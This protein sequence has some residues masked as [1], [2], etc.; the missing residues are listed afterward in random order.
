MVSMAAAAS[1]RSGSIRRSRSE[2]RLRSAVRRTGVYCP[3]LSAM[4]AAGALASAELAG[5]AS[6]PPPQAPSPTRPAISTPWIHCD[7]GTP[8]D[9]LG[10]EKV[11]SAAF[12]VTLT[13]D[14]AL[15]PA[16]ARVGLGLQKPLA[17]EANEGHEL[18]VL[19]FR[20][21]VGDAWDQPVDQHHALFQGEGSG[22][23]HQSA[24]RGVVHPVSRLARRHGSSGN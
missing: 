4:L 18:L 16:F 10:D 15:R 21:G 9:G 11:S 5:A 19:L 24:D 17:L 2:R 20:Q 1:I 23:I 6:W 12:E 7:I 8:G 14:V 22:L 13:G 3:T